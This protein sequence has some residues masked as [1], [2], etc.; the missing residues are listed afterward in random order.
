MFCA[1]VAI[2]A[3]GMA[4]R[5]SVEEVILSDNR[6]SS[7]HRPVVPGKGAQLALCKTGLE[8][9][10]RRLGVGLPREAYAGVVQEPA[11]SCALPR[12]ARG[13]QGRGGDVGATVCGGGG[14][15]DGHRHR[16]RSHRRRRR[17]GGGNGRRRRRPTAAV[18]R[19]RL[20]AASRHRCGPRGRRSAAAGGRVARA[21]LLRSAQRGAP[22]PRA[23]RGLAAGC[24]V[25][26]VAAG[27]VRPESA[28]RCAGPSA[29]Q[30]RGASSLVVPRR[31]GRASCSGPG[32]VGV[33]VAA[34][35]AP[36]AAAARLPL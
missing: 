23:S 19:R 22:S 20:A 3:R 28:V 1:R 26:A 34:R 5:Q 11:D 27:A 21:P 12:G 4:T 16:H 35:I 29:G 13:C 18:G 7:I 25:R 30:A 8:A 24:R 6:L 9:T 31:S 14:Y 15:P 17:H 33:R 36:R 32:R 10:G 2:S